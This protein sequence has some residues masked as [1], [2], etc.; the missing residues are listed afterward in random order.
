MDTKLSQDCWNDSERVFLEEGENLCRRFDMDEINHDVFD[1]EKTLH[2]VQIICL[3]NSFRSV[4][5]SLR[6]I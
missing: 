2:Q 6:K 4:G 3:W 5:I 1:M